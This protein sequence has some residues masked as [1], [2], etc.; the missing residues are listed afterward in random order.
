MNHASTGCSRQSQPSGSSLRWKR[1]GGS[2]GSPTHRSPL[3]PLP[4]SP[5]RPV[6]RATLRAP[7]ARTPF[8]APGLPRTPSPPATAHPPRPAAAHRGARPARGGRSRRRA[9]RLSPPLGPGPARPRGNGLRRRPMRRRQAGTWGTPYQSAAARRAGKG[10]VPAC[11][12]A[13]GRSPGAGA[14]SWAAAGFAGPGA[15]GKNG[16]FPPQLEEARLAVT[17]AAPR[18]GGKRERTVPM[19]AVAEN[20]AERLPR[21]VQRR[22]RDRAFI[23]RSP[24]KGWA[25]EGKSLLVLW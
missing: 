14:S 2:Q 6:R 9:G 7:S 25:D 20:L 10:P 13:G 8:L 24:T 21:G 1:K 15:P 18:S 17:R 23:R 16:K 12:A 22:D 11:P 19:A 4:P 3:R 5:P